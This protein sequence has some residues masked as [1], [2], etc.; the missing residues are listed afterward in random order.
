MG[1]MELKLEGSCHCGAVKFSVDSK[2][3]VP[4]SRCY[5]TICRKT[6]GGGGYTINLLADAR[7]LSVD[8]EENITIY[9]ANQNDRGVY[10]SDGLGF[11]QRHFC[12]QCGSALWVHNP[13]WP[14]YIH[15]FASAIDTDL[16]KPPE[17]QSIMTS[18]AVNWV[19]L[20]DGPHFEN[21][22][23]RGLEDWHKTRGLYLD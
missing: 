9:R 1:V 5:C 11:S 2:A 20:P 23:E 19:D 14:D 13:K 3:P 18:H 7:T 8:G 16:P 10:D 22:P 17:I 21:Y 4:F 15:P 12:A 6:S